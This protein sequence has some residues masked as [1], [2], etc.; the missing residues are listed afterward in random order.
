MRKGISGPHMDKHL[1]V[2]MTGEIRMV[3]G[4]KD[5]D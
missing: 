5:I 4:L 2:C 3:E 1:D